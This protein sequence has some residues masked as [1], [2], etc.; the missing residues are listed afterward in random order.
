MNKIFLA[1]IFVLIGLVNIANGQVNEKLLISVNLQTNGDHPPLISGTIKNEKGEPIE[2]A[3]VTISSSL[4]T[5]E[6]KSDSDGMFIYGLS[7]MPTESKFNVSLKAQKDGYL[8]GYAN[9]S[10]FVKNDD[11]PK[12][13]T[14]KPLGTNFKV[15]SGDEI[16]N[17][18]IAFKILQNIELN[19]QKEAERQKKLQEIEERQKFLE[20]QRQIA[21]QAMLN[22]LQDWFAQFDP[23]QP[24]NVFAS[25]ASQFD[26][27]LQTIYW[28]QFNF[29][30]AKTNEGLMAFQ[31]ILNTGGTVQ[32]ARNAF[33]E[34]AAIKQSDINNLNNDLN[35]KYAKNDTRSRSDGPSSQ[36]TD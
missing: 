33:Y 26:A 17:N 25:F 15:A 21:N 14:T 31:Q 28:A 8:T 9:T 5:I 4:E 20:E 7:S 2:G 12:A 34:K 32:D 16:K 24:R 1:L 3:I 35:A 19:K 29:T 10:F 36:N 13:E 18:P 6:T 23:F 27:T 11:Q 30:E 22:D